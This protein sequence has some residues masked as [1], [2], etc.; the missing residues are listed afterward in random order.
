MFKEESMAMRCRQHQSVAKRRVIWILGSA[1]LYFIAKGG[2]YGHEE[3][4]KILLDAGAISKVSSDTFYGALPPAYP[5]TSLSTAGS[6]EMESSG[7]LWSVQWSP[8]SSVAHPG[9][10]L[11]INGLSGDVPLESCKPSSFAKCSLKCMWIPLFHSSESP[12]RC[13]G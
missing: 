6:F 4:V 2:C 7:W 5:A 11:P 13:V 3:V 12:P 9:K 10:Y 1:G 8:A